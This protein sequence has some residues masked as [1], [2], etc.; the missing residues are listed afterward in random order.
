MN[1]KLTFKWISAV[2]GTMI[3]LSACSATSPTSATP[4]P[5]GP[6]L[7]RET[8]LFEFSRAIPAGKPVYLAFV[9]TDKKVITSYS[10]EAAIVKKEVDVSKLGEPFSTV[11]K[12]ALSF[13]SPTAQNVVGPNPSDVKIYPLSPVVYQD[14]NENSIIDDGELF[15][16]TK[17]Y[18]IYST[19]AFTGSYT[20]TLEGK[21]LEATLYVN[22]GWSQL[23]YYI[24][25]PTIQGNKYRL[26]Q[27]STKES[28]FN[29]KDPT[30]LGSI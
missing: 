14:K 21:P 1:L 19:K 4:I 11:L 3:A 5:G 2:S 9:D 17:D 29:M 27:N 10:L 12:P 25:G 8:A 13:I 20:D 16:T 26:I 22:A 18:I 23:E 28:N 6:P 24:Y 7:A 30:T 15:L